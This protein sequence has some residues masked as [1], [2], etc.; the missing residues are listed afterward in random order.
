M[1]MH[2]TAQ[3]L[4]IHLKATFCISVG[5]MLQHAGSL[6]VHDRRSACN[7]AGSFQHMERK[8]P[9]ASAWGSAAQPLGN[10]G[11]FNFNPGPVRRKICAAQ[12]NLAHQYLGF[13]SKGPASPWAECSST[14]VA[15][16]F[17]TEDL[18]AMR[19]EAFSTRSKKV[20]R[21]VHEGALLNLWETWES[22]TL[23]RVLC[24]G[25]SAQLRAI[26]L[27]NISASAPKALHL[28]GR[29]APARR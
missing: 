27:T 25:K 28:R 7:A 4:R 24:G 2:S 6:E 11:K 23:I 1:N 10:L 14:Q 13:S 5:G 29:N 22:S 9:S 8:D 21:P 18:H 20:L 12:S 17:M 16:K 19:L 15:W 3:P 26:L